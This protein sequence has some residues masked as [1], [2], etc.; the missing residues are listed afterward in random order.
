[1]ELFKS[2]FGDE[3]IA[4]VQA[5][6]TIQ[7]S[8]TVQTATQP[9]AQA[10]SNGMPTLNGTVNPNNGV[11]K[12]NGAVKPNG[13]TYAKGFYKPYVPVVREVDTK[14]TIILVENTE[15]VVKE[16]D[17]LEAFVKKL[18]TNGYIIVLNYG[19]VV[20]ESKIVEVKNFDCGGL[21][22][23]EFAGNSACLFDAIIALEGVVEKYYKKV[24]EIKNNKRKRIK[25]I[26]IVAIG[27]CVDNCS[28]TSREI[29]LEIF[30]AIAKYHD[31]TTKYF[32]LSEEGFIRAATIGFHSIGAIVRN[33]M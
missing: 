18:D 11:S 23:E 10:T 9:T 28:I 6:D 13:V 8:E 15:E 24:E 25:S 14:L 20:R 32:C 12:P 31:V 5:D 17:K 22:Y 27:R 1:M 2:F 30:S 29:A 7:Q 26:D 4:E 19:R 21:V 3:P 16:K 33:Y